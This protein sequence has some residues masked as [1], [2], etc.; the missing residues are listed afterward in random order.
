MLETGLD[1]V[2]LRTED[3]SEVL[4]LSAFL[5]RHDRRLVN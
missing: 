3:P 2:V 5:V 4:E 1:G